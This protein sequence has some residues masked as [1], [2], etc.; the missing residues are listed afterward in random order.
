MRVRKT[1]NSIHTAARLVALLMIGGCSIHVGRKDDSEQE[2]PP[3]GILI[4]MVN[5]TEFALDP[6]LYVGPVSEGLS[7]LF[8]SAN[9]QTDFGVGGRGLLAANSDAALTVPCDPAVFIATQGGAVGDDLDNPIGQGQEI[10]LEQ[11]QNVYCGQM[12]TFTFTASGVTSF[13]VEPQ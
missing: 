13:V 7:E 4:K 9:L 1:R 10:V 3:P 8:R 5:D 12:I 2:A 6:Q 11:D